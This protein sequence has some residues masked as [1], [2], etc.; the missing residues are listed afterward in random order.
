M[1]RLEAGH[2]YYIDGGYFQAIYDELM[3]QFSLWTY[4]GL[5]GY[6]IGRTG[7]EVGPQGQLQDRIFD[8]ETG[9]QVIFEGRELTVDDLEEVDVT[10]FDAN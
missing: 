6:V 10:E 3:E 9:K 4:L 1:K 2:V 5:A 8:F 7:F